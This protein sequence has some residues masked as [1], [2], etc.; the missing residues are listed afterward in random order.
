MIDT[1]IR[2]IAASVRSS[3][4]ASEIPPTNIAVLLAFIETSRIGITRG[5]LRI[6]MRVED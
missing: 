2:L 5:K 3:P 4:C 1:E 6:A